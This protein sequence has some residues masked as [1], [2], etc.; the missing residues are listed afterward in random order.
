MA[1]VDWIIIGVMAAAVLASLVV[2]LRKWKVLRSIDVA[3]MPAV[4]M[5]KKKYD[6]IEQRLNRKVQGSGQ[7]FTALFRA[8]GQVIAGMFKTLFDKLV[9][10]ER[11]YRMAGIGADQSAQGREKTRQKV[12]GLMEEART[13]M[14]ADNIVEAENILVDVI[15]LRPQEKD[16]YSML[17]TVYMQKKEHENAIETLQHLRKMTDDDEQVYYGLG[18]AYEAAEEMEHALESYKKAVEIAPKNP[19]NLNSLLHAAIGVSDRF[20]ARDAL[21]GLKEADPENGKLKELEEK[22]DAL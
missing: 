11:K 2:I 21:R 15:R 20:L 14:E 4:Q 12:A 22:I 3:A 19:R 1:L 9:E 10:Q 8:V 13:H 16:A 6:L 5:R 7:R 18:Q 17:A